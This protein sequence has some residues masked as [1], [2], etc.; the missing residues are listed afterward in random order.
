M[1]IDFDSDFLTKHLITY[2]GNKRTLLQFINSVILEIQHNLGKNSLSI[3]D[4]FAGTGCVSRLFK[5]YAEVL[6][7]NDIEGYSET[8][9]KCYL[10]NKSEVDLNKVVQLINLANSNKFRNSCV[11]FIA[12]NYAP[13]DDNN[14][15]YGE[16]V[17][18]T[19]NNAKII[20]NIRSF[21][22]DDIE[23]NIAHYIL[24]P[25]IVKASIHTNTSG[26]FKGFH[27]KNKIG[28]FGGNGENALKRIKS[29]IVLD[30]PIFCEYECPTYIIRKD[31]NEAIHC[32]P[33]V[34]I[35]YYDPPYN[36]HPY[37]S[38]Y[39]MLNIINDYNNPKIQNGVSG[40]IE[41]WNRSAY[42]KK[43]VAVDAMNNLIDQTKAKYILI[44]YNNEGIIPM[45]VFENILS[46]YGEVD[47]RTCK[48]NTYRG[49]KNTGSGKK[50][51]NGK[52][53]DLHV[54]EMLW[55]LKKK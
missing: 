1:N 27:K 41:N 25:L 48:Y 33:E 42:N 8:V 9:N 45:D 3:L 11:G 26:V 47:L 29:D 17:F 24:A 6:Y 49:S 28:H 50:L 32:I 37:G 46:R 31:I 54:Q 12:Q 10:S 51:L 18:Y 13:K 20:D 14:I 38:N 23:Q 34:D 44:S 19:N 2:L 39:F 40:I 55:I 16:R 7:V 21:I 30:I 52:E 43:N 35:A 5:H 22:R 36:Q 15:Q 4:G 53:R